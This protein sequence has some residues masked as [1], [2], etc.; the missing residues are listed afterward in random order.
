MGQKQKNRAIESPRPV[1]GT[2]PRRAG[3]SAGSWWIILLLT[4]VICAVFWSVLSCDF[5][6]YDDPE[7]V[8]ENAVVAGGFTL[9]GLRWAFSSGYASNWHPVTWLSHMMDAQLFGLN[10]R[11]HH[12][13][14]LLLHA[15]NTVLLF[16]LLRRMTGAR[17]RSAL[18]AALFGLHPLHVESVAWISER[19][20]VLSAFFGI[21]SLIFYVQYVALS[22]VHPSSLR[23][24]AA[25]SQKSKIFY[26]AAL[27]ALAL[28]L[29]SKAMLVT[30]PFVVLLLD[31]WPLRR[32]Q[33]SGFR[34]QGWKPLLM[35]KIPFFVLSAASCAVTY[36]VQDSGGAVRD[37][38]IF[39]A[40]G[41]VENALVAY[42]RYLGKTFWPVDM[43]VFYPH[44]GHWPWLTV[45]C[46]VILLAGLTC[47]AVWFVKRLPFLA[48]GWFWFLGTLI[49]VIGL[50]QV[51]HQAMADRYTYLPH[52]GVFVV[53][54]WGAAEALDCLRL[55]KSVR[56]AF[57]LL[58]L[59]ACALVTTK[60]LR[61]WRDSEVLFRHALAVTKNNPVA[62]HN[63]GSYLL[64][65]GEVQEAVGLFKDALRYDPD[66]L[67]VYN[68]LGAALIQMGDAETAITYLNILV[69]AAPNH[70]KAHDNLGI[71]FAKM[72]RLDEAAAQFRQAIR[73]QPGHADTHFNLG[74][75]LA[76][77]HKLDDALREFA[78]TLRLQPDHAWAHLN[79]GSALAELGRRDE[80]IAH[81]REAVRLKPDFEQANVLLRSLTES[82]GQ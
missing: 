8:T 67:E 31:W 79:M 55:P 1:A 33:G 80:A 49:P 30:W 73:Y 13:T 75:V 29:M 36:G 69:E 21:W 65:R 5:V 15:L 51:G 54:V 40:G 10:P 41:R 74:N 26:G 18:V 59:V 28:G 20:D 14:S 16:V 6:N 53:L 3:A 7:Y 47:V 52:I 81:L 19:K 12:F 42:A 25:R 71:A 77:Q 72:G 17:W 2:N 22:K 4:A 9:E 32:V 43:A 61:H 37:V 64:K 68:N 39:S 56:T 60:Q 35:E 27:L 23:S 50:V 34:V 76:L 62:A 46:C 58:A 82:T 38:A 63:L 78:E 57:S 11:G 45:I 70:A 66:F 24:D 44:P 48:T